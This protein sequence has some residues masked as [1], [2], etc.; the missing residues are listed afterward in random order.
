MLTDEVT[1]DF[2]NHL[3]KDDLKLKNANREVNNLADQA[4]NGYSIK[5]VHIDSKYNAVKEFLFSVARSRIRVEDKFSLCQS[6]WL[7]DYSASYSTPEII[8][9]YRS[10]R[11]KSR[12]M[13]D[14]GA[15]ACMQAIMF[16]EHNQVTAIEEDPVRANLGRLNAKAYDTRS[17]TVMTGDAETYLS[18]AIHDDITV[19]TDPLRLSG[20]EEKTFE[21]LMPN[22]KLI[23]NALG[24][25]ISGYIID[26]PP[27]FPEKN[28]TLE[29]EREYIS[30]DGRINRFT[31]Y[32]KEL[33][34]CERSAVI[35]PVNKRIEGTKDRESYEH[36]ERSSRFLLMPDPALMYA[37]LVNKAFDP[38][39]FREFA[40]DNRRLVL[41]SDV[42][43]KDPHTCELFEVLGSSK[44]DDIRNELGRL[45]PGK[46]IPRFSVDP[47]TYYNFTRSL[48]DPLW[49]GES[50]YL[51]RNGDGIVLAKKIKTSLN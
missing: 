9:R 36:A 23:L 27:L 40:R 46:V 29:G 8:G 1:L 43:P 45:K 16:S 28:I 17:L 19:F 48:I 14:F 13:I 31:L 2:T 12:E 47:E 51:F 7:D 42:V 38:A 34:K 18:G 26:L 32:S 22:P 24:D 35:L 15:G 6:I 50:I 20:R 11:V 5:N 37:E 10:G 49:V 4:R 30:L 39:D 41:T 25:K 44:E 33:M 3:L 21:T